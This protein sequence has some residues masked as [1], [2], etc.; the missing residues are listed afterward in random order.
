MPIIPEAR[1]TEMAISPL[2]RAN[3]SEV[4]R[5]DTRSARSTSREPNFFIVGAAR[6]GTTSLW[7]RLRQHP[8]I[9]MP[10]EQK[11]PHFFCESSPPWAIKKFEDYLALFAEARHESAIG[12]ASTGYLNSPETPALIRRKYP[13]AKIIIM[14]RDPVERAYSLYRLNCALG[15]EW[16]STFEK[17]LRAEEKRF[18]NERFKRNNP[19]YY[20][21]YLYFRSGLIAESLERYVRTFPADQIHIILF[22]EYKKNPGEATSEVFRFLGVDPHYVPQSDERHASGFPFWVRAH[23]LLGRW[24]NRRSKGGVD[25]PTGR[26][27]TWCSVAWHMNLLFGATFRPPLTAVKTERALRKRYADDISATAALIGRDLRAWS[28]EKTVSER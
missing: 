22:D 9:F 11:E 6:A 17:A 23:Y 28:A 13:H 21:A 19:Y 4:M 12:E 5:G 20:E 1:I 10:R 15:Y 7:Y 27:A 16:L 24:W 2:S 14:L 25:Q 8:D 3:D 26:A 18:E